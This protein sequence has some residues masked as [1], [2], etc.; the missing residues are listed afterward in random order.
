VHELAR[1]LEAGGPVVC[2]SMA[3]ASGTAAIGIGL[4]WIRSGAC[5]AVVAGGVDVLSGLVHAGF[6]C[7]KALDPVRP[8]PFDRDRAGLGIG[9]GAA[10]VLLQRGLPDLI[11]EA[12]RVT[13]WAQSADAVHLTGPDATGSGLARAIGQ[14]LEEAGL[15]PEQV[16]FVSAHG[17]ATEYNDLMEGKALRQVFGDRVDRL[18]VNSIKGAIGHTM[19]AAGAIE[20]VLCTSVLEHGLIPPTANLEH[21]DPEIPLN[22]V[23]GRAL[24][25]P[26]QRAVTTSSGFGGIN[27]ALVIERVQSA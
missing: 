7:L 3:C 23:Q 17:T 21:Q 12:P 1:L 20:A 5:D 10:L 24:E 4:E 2:P 14:A 25:A 8:R 22:V 19:A 26:V 18:P 15:R 27:A 9:E 6:A 16:D 11:T 13:G